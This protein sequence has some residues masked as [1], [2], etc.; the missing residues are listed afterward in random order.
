[1]PAA[2]RRVERRLQRLDDVQARGVG[3]RVLHPQ[4]ELGGARAGAGHAPD[5]A[6]E[7]LPVGVPDPRHVAPVRRAVVEDAEQLELPVL[8]RQ[9]AQDLVGA[10]GVLDEQ[11]RHRPAP[12]VDGLG[13]AEG[14][15]HGLQPGDDGG[16]RGAEGQAERGRAERVVDVVEA[17]Q[18]QLDP[19]AAG[20]RLE[21][22]RR[23]ADPAQLHGARH[24]RRLGPPRAAVRAASSGRGARG[25]SPR[26]RRD[27]RSGGSA[28]SRRRA[29]APRRPACRR[30]R[31]SRAAR[32]RAR[33]R[34][35][36]GRRR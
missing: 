35:R 19:G 18:R 9:R 27:G 25:R 26:R 7:Q 33:D 10:R 17:G 28:W 16:Q 4:R 22:E 31:R 29:A 32:A 2:T 12:D 23:G 13:A 5:G 30:R 36:A 3:A 20:R 24:H 34:P 14:G 21:R 6:H 1:M 8:E 15:R 11:D